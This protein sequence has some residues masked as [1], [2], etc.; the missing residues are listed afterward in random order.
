MFACAK[1]SC[2]SALVRS[3]SWAGNRRPD[4]LPWSVHVVEWGTAGRRTP[5]A[6]GSSLLNL[7]SLVFF[8]LFS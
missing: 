7:E 6:R 2:T 4:L 1:L 8:F 3:T 5:P